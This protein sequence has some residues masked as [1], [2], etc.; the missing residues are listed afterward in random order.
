M[1]LSL[2]ILS[3][4]LLHAIDS[5]NSVHTFKIERA[6][7]YY[8]DG[9]ASFMH[10]TGSRKG[11][12]FFLARSKLALLHFLLVSRLGTHPSPPRKTASIMNN[13]RTTARMRV[14]AIGP[15]RKF[16]QTLN[17]A[18]KKCASVAVM[19]TA[20]Q[21]ERDRRTSQGGPLHCAI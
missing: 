6:D 14:A 4:A 21:A 18:G 13:A 3:S 2:Y 8:R 1:T 5:V 20:D 12:L 16:V 17:N 10:F 15:A 19:A 7:L 11:S 9:L